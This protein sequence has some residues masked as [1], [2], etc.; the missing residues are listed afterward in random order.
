M[1]RTFI[2]KKLTYPSVLEEEILICYILNIATRNL[3]IKMILKCSVNLR[4]EL[5]SLW[6]LTNVLRFPI[7]FTTRIRAQQ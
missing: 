7:N 4:K 1:N 2:L 6:N 3:E 5:M